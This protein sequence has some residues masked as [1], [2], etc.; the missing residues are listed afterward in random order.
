MSSAYARGPPR[1]ERAAIALAKLTVWT[2][3]IA[4]VKE[5]AFVLQAVQRCSPED[6]FIPPS[7][8][9]QCQVKLLSL[10]KGI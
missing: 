1:M 6:L 8:M 4:I 10:C 3:I 9:M 5:V 7:S 2:S